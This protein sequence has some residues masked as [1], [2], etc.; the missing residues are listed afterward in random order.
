MTRNMKSLLFECYKLWTNS[1]QIIYHLVNHWTRGFVKDGCF[2]VLNWWEIEELTE[3]FEIQLYLYVFL[4]YSD[5]DQ[6]SYD[7]MVIEIKVKLSKLR[8]LP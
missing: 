4:A 1:V 6:Y 3:L 5:N 7:T 8:W 2:I